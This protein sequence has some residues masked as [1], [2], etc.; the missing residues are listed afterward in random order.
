MTSL[1]CIIYMHE[2]DPIPSSGYRV[3]LIASSKHSG[4][5]SVPVPK[6]QL[7]ALVW[8]MIYDIHIFIHVPL[9]FHQRMAIII[10]AIDFC[11]VSDLVILR[12]EDC[13]HQV[14]RI[15]PGSIKSYSLCNVYSKHVQKF[16]AE[17]QPCLAIIGLYLIGLDDILVM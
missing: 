16:V 13:M 1:I 7:K 15:H 4:G 6:A 5:P 11:F 2:P 3:R 10:P 17:I 12:L 9:E 8:Y 14:A